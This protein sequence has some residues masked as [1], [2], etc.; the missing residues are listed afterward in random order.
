MLMIE[1]LLECLRL[2]MNLCILDR[3]QRG[4]PKLLVQN[5]WGRER[6]RGQEKGKLKVQDLEWQQSRKEKRK[7]V[8]E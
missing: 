2:A 7:E 8:K 5:N 3:T 1:K 4:K 6:D